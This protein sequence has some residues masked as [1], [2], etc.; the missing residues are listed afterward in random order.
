MG[1]INLSKH[2]YMLNLNLQGGGIILLA[3]VCRVD[4]KEELTTLISFLLPDT[5]TLVQ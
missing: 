4:G 2:K 3:L 1:E 5:K